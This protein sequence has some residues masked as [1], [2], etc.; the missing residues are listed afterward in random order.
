MTK[1]AIWDALAKTDPKHTKPFNRAGGFKGTAVK[2]IWIIKRLT[3]YFGPCG[4]GW[5][6][7]EPSFQVVPGDGELLVFC[8]VSAWHGSRDNVIWGVGGDKVQA[9]RSSGAFCD[10]EAFKK[11]FTDAV[12]NAFK[13]M[14]VA[15]DVHMGL[16]DDDKYVSQA[17]ADFAE[18]SVPEQTVDDAQFSELTLLLETAKADTKAFCDY[19]H[20]ASVRELP[21]SRYEHARA[22]LNK[23]IKEAA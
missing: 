2:P 20:I 10:D 11:A 8:T 3:D 13:F 9:K 5:G 12:N 15:A 21:A 23:K 7:N 4:V 18:T 22:M 14:G 19:Y 1:T 6:V 16:F 17:K